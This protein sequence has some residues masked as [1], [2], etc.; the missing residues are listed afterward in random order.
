MTELHKG[1]PLAEVVTIS[2]GNVG[3]SGSAD[4]AMVPLQDYSTCVEGLMEGGADIILIETIFDVLNS[5]AAIYAARKVFAEKGT[6]LP[7]MVSGTITD[8]SGRLLSGQ[9]TEAFWASIQ[10]AALRELGDGGRFSTRTFTARYRDDMGVRI[11]DHFTAW[12][13]DALVMTHPELLDIVE[14]RKRT[15]AGPFQ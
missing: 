13:A 10:S 9:T 14:R 7:I 1:H 11:N 12:F 4:C 8:A 15:K 5:K 3:V 2:P 6:S